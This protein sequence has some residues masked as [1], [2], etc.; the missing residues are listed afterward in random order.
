MREVVGAAAY[1]V[2]AGNIASALAG[3][4]VAYQTVLPYR[5]GGAR[6]VDAQYIPHIG[7]D[8]RTRGFYAFIVDV[9][10]RQ[11][12][13]AAMRASEARYRA[14]AEAIAA[15]IWTTGPD[16]RATE[17]PQWRALTG[18]TSEEVRGLGWLDAVHPDDRERA[19][20]AWQGC[21]AAGTPCDVEYPS[22]GATATT[23][24]S[25]A[26]A[27]RCAARTARCASGS[28]SAS[29]SAS[30]SPPRSARRS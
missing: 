23:D 22:A 15:V 29:T 7:P 11:R 19:R 3:E 17:M 25:M 6:C 24:G 1:E 16:G 14:L 9:T 13:E 27:W 5:Q 18:Q 10:E 20:D 21:V 28:A 30:A 2:V 12:G 26:G 4:R 8:G